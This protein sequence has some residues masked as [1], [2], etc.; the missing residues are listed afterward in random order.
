MHSQAV[1]MAH[2]ELDRNACLEGFAIAT[3]NFCLDFVSLLKGYVSWTQL[4]GRGTKR[5]DVIT[6]ESMELLN[7]FELAYAP[8][9][10]PAAKMYFSFIDL[11]TIDIQ[12][13][14]EGELY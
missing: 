11:K 5:I 7:Y 10:N 12:K 2:F 1:M 14:K 9:V 3:N 6:F 8:E 13:Y 4:A